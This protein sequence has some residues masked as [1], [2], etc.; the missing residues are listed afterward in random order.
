MTGLQLY[1]LK[2]NLTI[3]HFAR[4][5][6]VSTKTLYKYSRG[7]RISNILNSTEKIEK[8]LRILETSVLICPSYKVYRKTGN[9][10]E[11]YDRK[12]KEYDEIFVQLFNE[13]E[14]EHASNNM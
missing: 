8:G 2:Y 12:V 6:G 3:P 14:G 11:G 7:Q 5:I 13:S 9:T 4:L 10:R 1:L